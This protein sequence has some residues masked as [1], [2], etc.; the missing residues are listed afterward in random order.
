[1]PSSRPVARV[2]R[3]ILR[4]PTSETCTS[5]SVKRSR[6]M[7]DTVA[8]AR[9]VPRANPAWVTSPCSVSSCS[10]RSRLELRNAACDPGW[11]W[12]LKTDMI[13]QPPTRRAL[14]ALDDRERYTR[15][16]SANWP[17]EHRP[18]LLTSVDSACERPIRLAMRPASSR[19]GGAEGGE[20]RDAENAFT[21][22]VPGDRGGPRAGLVRGDADDQPGGQPERQPG[23]HRHDHPWA[24]GGPVL[25]AGAEG[26]PAGGDGLQRRPAL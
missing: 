22:A 2:S 10:T 9:P 25:G 20:R 5:P 26:R 14:E 1:M 18:P 15:A 21:G 11:S 13:R 16:R 23:E 24:G 19:A 3:T 8:A 4:R 12:P 17:S 6:T 7:F